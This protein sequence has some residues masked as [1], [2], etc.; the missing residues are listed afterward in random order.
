M[1]SFALIDV[2]Y[3]RFGYNAWR[4][5]QLP[6]QILERLCKDI[7]IGEPRYGAGVVTVGGM[8]FTAS[9]TVQDEAG[10]MFQHYCVGLMRRRLT[11]RF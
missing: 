1:K 2:I 11:T 3:L 5:P 4:D 10:I 7:K 6:T 9:E 8:Q